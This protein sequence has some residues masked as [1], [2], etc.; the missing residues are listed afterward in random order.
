MRFHCNLTFGLL[1]AALASVTPT[2]LV[3]AVHPVRASHAMV[4]SVH[5][6]ASRAGIEMMQAGGN[7]IDAAVAT[8]FALAVVHPQAGNIGGGGFMLI[9]MADGTTHFLD[10]REKAPAAA[11]HDMFLDAHGNVSEHTSL[12]GY[13]A[14]AVPGSVKGMAYAQKKWGKLPLATVM[15]PAIRLA[16]QG[17]ELS[18]SE[19][20]DFNND[21][22]LGE[23]PASKKI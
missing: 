14:I 5:E 22:F 8:G 7:A 16:R 18:Y 17:F 21:D 1:L 4:A 10:Y 12:I 2:P 11:T 20:H 3:A 6:L 19:A 15:A 13:K 23:F 9:R